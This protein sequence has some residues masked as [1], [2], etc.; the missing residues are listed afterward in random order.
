VLRLCNFGAA[1]AGPAEPAHAST[2]GVGE[3]VIL[4]A[5]PRFVGAND[6]HNVAQPRIIGEIPPTFPK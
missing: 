4:V 6:Q 5:M 1:E 3:G 2:N